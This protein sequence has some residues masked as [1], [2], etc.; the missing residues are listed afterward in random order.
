MDLQA[1]LQ[2]S[3]A[4]LPMA[5]VLLSPELVIVDA[6]E[7]YSR[8]ALRPREALLGR[9]LLDVFPPLPSS[10]LGEG[11]NPLGDFL[12]RV[13]TSGQPESLSVLRYD[14]LD[15]SSGR[16]LPRWWSLSAGAVRDD[17]GAVTHVVQWVEDVSA[18][19][20][21]GVSADATPRLAGPADLHRALHANAVLSERL[22]SLAAVAAE[23]TR[24][25]SVGDLEAVVVHRGLSVLGAD[26]GAIISP[27]EEGGWRATLARDRKSVV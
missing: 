11:P 13:A 27:H 20:E 23:L 19:V 22:A 26:G 25:Q 14:V 17:D 16:A 12:T 8:L 10:L 4:R 6:S 9:A 1:D 2:P 24:A 7:A 18:L 3:F 5:C 15:P 21:S